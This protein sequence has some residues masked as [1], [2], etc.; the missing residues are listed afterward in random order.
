MDVCEHVYSGE[1]IVTILQ[2]QFHKSRALT[3]IE[4]TEREKKIAHTS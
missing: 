2:L 3:F 1:G 4:P